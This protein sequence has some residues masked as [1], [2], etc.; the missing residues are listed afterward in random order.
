MCK[1]VVTFAALSKNECN[2]LKLTKRFIK[3]LACEEPGL[4]KMSYQLTNQILVKKWVMHTKNKVFFH[5]F[6]NGLQMV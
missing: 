5:S 2:V 3:D 6:F 4:I 1:T